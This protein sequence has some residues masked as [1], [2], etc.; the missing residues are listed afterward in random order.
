MSFN[1]SRHFIEAW[2]YSG[3]V[4]RGKNLFFGW[5]LDSTLYA[6][7]NYGWGVNPYQ[8]SFLSKV[9]DME[10][11][12]PDVL[13]LKRLCRVEPKQDVYL[14][15]FISGCHKL[16]KLNSVKV[17]VSFSDPYHNHTGGIYRA[18]NFTHIGTTKEEMHCIDSEGSIIHRRIAYRLSKRKGISISEARA[19]LG[20]VPH[21]T[22]A[23]DRWAI[24][25]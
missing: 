18:S 7:A 15:Q 5:Y 14:S 12:N 10:L 1:D 6:I 23:K 2:H 24:I 3:C 21:K 16:L 25:L 13:E 9:L 19:S 8:A 22:L 11:T 4:P 20:L 17:I